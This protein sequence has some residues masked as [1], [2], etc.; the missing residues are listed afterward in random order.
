MALWE[1][2]SEDEEGEAPSVSLREISHACTHLASR[3]KKVINPEEEQGVCSNKVP[4]P[5]QEN[6]V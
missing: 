1:V 3:T 6:V 4:L 2:V 5:F